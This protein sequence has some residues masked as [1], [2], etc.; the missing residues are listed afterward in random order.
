MFSSK[1]NDG[2]KDKFEEALKIIDRLED[3]HEKLKEDYKH[4]K[5]E[6]ETLKSDK[7]APAESE[8]LKPLP[9]PSV[10][11]AAPA[12]PPTSPRQASLPLG[13]SP[14]PIRP[15]APETAAEA[16]AAGIQKISEELKRLGSKLDEI[17]QKNEMADRLH[18][19]V[20]K[21]HEEL[22]KYKNDLIWKA[23][24]PLLVGIV[25]MNDKI[26]ETVGKVQS[27]KETDP[28]KIIDAFEYVPEMLEETLFRQ[29]VTDYSTEPGNALNVLRH[30]VVKPVIETDDETK[31]HTI[32]LSLRNG[33]EY[34]G[35]MVAEELVR[36]F[37][38]KPK[39]AE[40]KAKS[41][42]TPDKSA[43]SAPEA[44]N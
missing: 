29:R 30:K 11:S 43:W 4:I 32:A 19:M 6:I 28:D 25:R 3:G 37:S 9:E 20:N 5:E 12:M 36:V 23:I 15:A 31:H 14:E 35:K 16:S 24:Q 8:H 17:A 1:K 34:E 44:T 18:V 38:Y 26:T 13:S 41:A 40:T 7:L 27:K 2:Y 21:L 42:S 39:S 33:Y 22:Q 10:T